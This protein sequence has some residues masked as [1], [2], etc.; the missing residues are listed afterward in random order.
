MFYV[1]VLVSD[2]HLDLELVEI[3]FKST[4]FFN[5]LTNS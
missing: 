3:F 1:D 5:L 2:V 4:V